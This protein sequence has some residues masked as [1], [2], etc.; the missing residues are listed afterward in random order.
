MIIGGANTPIYMV[1]VS[2]IYAL[3]NHLGFDEEGIENR[4]NKK[5]VNVEKLRAGLT[6]IELNLPIFTPR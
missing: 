4:W 1:A 5:K 3:M 2:S 6:E